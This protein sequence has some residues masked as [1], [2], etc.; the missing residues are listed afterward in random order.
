[1]KCNVCAKEKKKSNLFIKNIHCTHAVIK[2]HESYYD[3][4][5][6]EHIHNYRCCESV[7]YRCS[8]SHFYTEPYVYTCPNPKCDWNSS[9]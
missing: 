7:E 5:G 3:E 6:D 4:D 8:N 2:F 9:K 1:M